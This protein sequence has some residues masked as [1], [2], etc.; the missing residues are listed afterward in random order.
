MR[1][2][3][4][5]TSIRIFMNPQHKFQPFIGKGLL[6]G[7]FL[8][9][10]RVTYIWHGIEVPESHSIPDRTNFQTLPISEALAAF[11]IKKDIPKDLLGNKIA[12]RFVDA[13]FEALCYTTMVLPAFPDAEAITYDP[14]PTFISISNPQP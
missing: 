14:A 5:K 11:G 10:S 3:D 13:P 9:D 6:G 12:F 2:T 8:N 1:I 4:I 7:G